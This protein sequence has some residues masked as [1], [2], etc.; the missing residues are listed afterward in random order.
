ML[1]LMVYQHNELFEHHPQ[2]LSNVSVLGFLV[3]V[4][5]YLNYYFY[6]ILQMMMLDLI[7]HQLIL[8]LYQNH[9][10]VVDRLLILIDLSSS[11]AMD[12]FLMFLDRLISLDSFVI[13][14]V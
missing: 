13:E 5:V 7:R 6:D 11:K 14:A 2:L 4:L 12:F 3:P 10:S 1:L 8:I 9:V